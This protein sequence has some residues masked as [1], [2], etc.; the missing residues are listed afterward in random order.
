MIDTALRRRFEFIEQ[1]PE[2]DKVNDPT[3]KAI[4]VELNKILVDKLDSAD[5]LIGHSY[6]MNKTID[7]LPKVL[8][9]SIIP[10]LYE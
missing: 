3:M 2:P 5:L 10:L 4:L 6:F 1:K 9:N 7:D 8:N